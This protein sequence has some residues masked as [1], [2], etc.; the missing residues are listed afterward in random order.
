MVLGL[1]VHSCTRKR[2]DFTSTQQVVASNYQVI[3]AQEA[4]NDAK[5]ALGR[6]T[7]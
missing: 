7:V 2:R 5:T 1:I 3:V 6:P 4:A